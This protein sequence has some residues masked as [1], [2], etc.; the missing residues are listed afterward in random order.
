MKNKFITIRYIW[1]GVLS[2]SFCCGH[3]FAQKTPF[4]CVKVKEDKQS[5]ILTMEEVRIGDYRNFMGSLKYRYGEDSEQY[6]FSLPDTAKFTALYGFSF[7]LP[8]GYPKKEDSTANELL[9]KHSTFPMVAISYEQAMAFCQW[10]EGN[11]N[12]RDKSY[13]WQ[14]SLPSKADYEMAFKNAKITQRKPL[15]VL[16]SWYK[17]ER[18][19]NRNRVFGLTD[20]VAEYMQDGTIVAGGENS[21]LKFID[22]KNDENSIGFR[23]KATVVSKK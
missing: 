5:L 20:N 6:K 10:E 23:Y 15:S 4:R 18:K 22:A 9:L 3:V 19:G 21:E 8:L 7:F 2:I 13:N 1:I 12:Q 14:Y 16:L 17:K 11:A